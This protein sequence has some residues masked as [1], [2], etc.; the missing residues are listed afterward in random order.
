MFT[1]G[2]SS[3]ALSTVRIEAS[4]VG[5]ATITVLASWTSAA[6]RISVS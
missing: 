6:F 4:S 2:F 3:R 5:R 1:F